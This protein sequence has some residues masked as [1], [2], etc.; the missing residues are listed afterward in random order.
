MEC[1]AKH[2]PSKWSSLGIMYW[3]WG[4]W[5]CGN[6]DRGW[7]WRHWERGRDANQSPAPNEKRSGQPSFAKQ[8][9][10]NL[11][12]RSL[13]T[14]IAVS[15]PLVRFSF[16]KRRKVRIYIYTFFLIGDN[17][18]C[19]ELSS[20]S[21]CTLLVSICLRCS[22][23]T[24]W[25]ADNLSPIFRM[26]K[27]SHSLGNPSQIYRQMTLLLLFSQRKENVNSYHIYKYNWLS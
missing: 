15:W 24:L 16:S 6:T 7:E 22:L 13:S 1:S 27:W 25:S 11:A 9:H 2:V 17:S 21:S 3:W 8:W 19:E 26:P 20:S 5:W 14:S 4:R 10:S 23:P 12:K 18:Q